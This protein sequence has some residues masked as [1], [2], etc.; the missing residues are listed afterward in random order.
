MAIDVYQESINKSFREYLV[1]FDYL[2]RTLENYGFVPVNQEEALQI[3]FPSAI[4][5]F[6]KL[7]EKMK[8]YVEKYPSKRNMYKQA[9]AMNESEKKISFLNKL[10]YLQENQKC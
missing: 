9:L 1:N 5:S 7:F 6:R 4:G 10:L 3:G 8:E 2:T